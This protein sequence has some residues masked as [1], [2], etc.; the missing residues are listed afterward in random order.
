MTRTSPKRKLYNYQQKPPACPCIRL[1]PCKRRMVE[2]SGVPILK[3]HTRETLPPLN[4]DSSV[5]TNSVNETDTKERIQFLQNLQCSTNFK[6][7]ISNITQSCY[8]AD[9]VL[10]PSPI[11]R[12]VWD[13]YTKQ[14]SRVDTTTF[15]SNVTNE[16]QY[17]WTIWY[18][19]SHTK[20]LVCLYR[21]P[22]VQRNAEADNQRIQRYPAL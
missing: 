21:W 11:T 5:A 8:K 18:M 1:E 19:H 20:A 3:F 14:F 22:Y 17:K 13:P 7:W 15:W 9:Q 2:K 6:S 10:I 4:K 16:L 12:Y